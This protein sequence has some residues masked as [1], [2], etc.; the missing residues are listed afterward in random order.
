MIALV[1]HGGLGPAA[2]QTARSAAKAQDGNSLTTAYCDIAPTN[3]TQTTSALNNDSRPYI[4]V[5]GHGPMSYSDIGNIVRDVTIVGPGRDAPPL[6]RAVIAAG[7]VMLPFA[8][9]VTIDGLELSQSSTGGVVYCAQPPVATVKIRNSLVRGNVLGFGIFNDGCLVTITQSTISG[10]R[11]GIRSDSGSITIAQSMISNNQSEGI[12]IQGG[13]FGISNN[14][15][16]GNGTDGSAA[17]DFFNNPQGSFAFNTVG[18]NGKDGGP[19]GA[20]CLNGQTL[21]ASIFWD[22]AKSPGAAPT[23]FAVNCR[24]I[25]VV[26]DVNES[27][28]APGLQQATPV[29][30]GAKLNDFTT[31][32]FRLDV[33]T[34]ANIRTNRMSVLDILTAPEAGGVSA[35]PLLDLFNTRRPQ[36]AGWEIGAHEARY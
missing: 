25:S 11:I 1:D 23:Q 14:F 19:G 33:S 4:L 5:T 8:G 26:T 27:L 20:L 34:P 15:I 7:T 2:C 32:D 31:N 35:L 29:F 28:S 10:N 18:H 21:E 24:F 36:N 6:S 3:A 22:N 9:A 16:W 12:N 13:S 30:V 17:V